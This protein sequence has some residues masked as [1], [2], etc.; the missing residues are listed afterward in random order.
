MNREALGRLILEASAG[1]HGEVAKHLAGAWAEAAEAAQAL[2]DAIACGYPPLS[3]DEIVALTCMQAGAPP[4]GRYI[5]WLSELFAI[6]DRLRAQGKRPMDPSG[7]TKAERAAHWASQGFTDN[8]E[9]IEA[10]LQHD[11]EHLNCKACG[12]SGH[13]DDAKPISL[14]YTYEVG[15]A[16]QR[17]IESVGGRQ[18]NHLSGTFRWSDCFEAMVRAATHA[19]QQA[20][21]SEPL[22]LGA[23]L[24]DGKLHATV[25]RREANGHATVVATAVIAESMLRKHDVHAAM[26]PAVQAPAVQDGPALTYS[27][28]QATKCAGCGEHKHTPLRV[29]AMGGYV[30]LTC[31][32]KKL[33]GL[34]GEFGYEDDPQLAGLVYFGKELKDAPWLSAALHLHEVFPPGTKA[35][36]LPSAAR[37][38]AQLFVQELLARGLVP[39]VEQIPLKPFAMGHYRTVVSVRPVRRDQQ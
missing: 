17:Y 4:E 33:G 14:A 8:G 32:D 27:S 25:M 3:R 16:A 19:T 22:H 26:T 11:A 30:C 34:L 39:T 2:T 31:I 37:R 21:A 15:E 36:D 5:D 24:T 1:T 35:I 29:D 23:C 20:Q 12:G 9:R 13:A 38:C 28:T 6:Y 10:R 7:M 18:F